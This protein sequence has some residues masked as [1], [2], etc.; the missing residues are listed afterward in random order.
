M[1]FRTGNA[2]LLLQIGSRFAVAD[3]KTSQI[4]TVGNEAATRLDEESLALLRL[5]ARG[6]RRSVHGPSGRTA[7]G[8]KRRGSV[9]Q[10]MTTTRSRATAPYSRSSR[11]RL[12]SEMVTTNE[13]PAIFSC[14]IVR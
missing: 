10:W 12:N 11:R 3:E 13:A 4:E 14:S 2:N 1:V 9:P 8:A 5:Q 7:G 6:R